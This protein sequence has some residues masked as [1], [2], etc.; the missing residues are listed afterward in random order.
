MVRTDRFW[1]F[2]T[3]FAAVGG[4]ILT[5][6]IYGPEQISILFGVPR[7]TAIQITIQIL[8]FVA[9]ILGFTY[10]TILIKQETNS[11]VDSVAQANS[12]PDELF[13]NF[14]V[15]PDGLDNSE[16]DTDIESEM[17]DEQM[18][19]DGGP[20]SERPNSSSSKFDKGSDD[21]KNLQYKIKSIEIKPSGKG[22]LVGTVVGGVLGLSFGT[23]G[24][25]ILGV[26]G[27]VFGNEAEYRIIERRR[28]SLLDYIEVPA[29]ADK[30]VL[31]EVLQNKRRREVLKSLFESDDNVMTIGELAEI[32]AAKENNVPVNS[33]SSDQRKRVYVPLY[34]TH[35]P[36]LDN[37]GL[38]N[39][40]SNRGLVEIS[41]EKIQSTTRVL[42]VFEDLNLSSS[43]I[44]V[45]LTI[46][47]ILLF[48]SIEAEIIS[49][50]HDFLFLLYALSV[51]SISLIDRLSN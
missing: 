28:I 41:E 48:A 33:L 8:L 47:F 46:F 36:K 3:G 23:I 7:A 20:L 24:V 9:I 15:D 39:Y 19:T 35:L 25:L 31:F 2:L 50:R 45:F 30:G 17:N 44:Y 27:A 11:V 14:D 13:E 43:E 32:V 16:E 12:F 40:D 49:F 38:V 22:A 5:Y 29:D 1:G 18:R 21:D 4:F 6:L 42:P 37:V 34:Q 26:L 51:L 10:L